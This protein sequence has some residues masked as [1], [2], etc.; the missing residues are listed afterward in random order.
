VSKPSYSERGAILVPALWALVILSVLVAGFAHRMSIEVGMAGLRQAQLRASWLARSGIRIG[1]IALTEDPSPEYDSRKEAWY[2]NPDLYERYELEDGWVSIVAAQPDGGGLPRFGIA[3]EE[4]RINLNTA[5]RDVLERVFEDHE[6]VVPAI[7]DWRDADDNALP[8]GAEASYYGNLDSPYRCRNGDFATFEE[9]QLVRGMTP[10]IMEEVR[11]LVTTYGDG[12]VNVNT[13]G[14]RVLECLGLSEDV[15]DA[16]LYHRAGS[17]GTEGTEDDMVFE[18][19][20]DLRAGLTE[21]IEL[22]EEEIGQID[23][24]V[25]GG[26]LSVRSRFYRVRAIGT[27][28]AGDARREITAVV[29]RQAGDEPRVVYWYE[30]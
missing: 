28:S 26:Y 11:G 12:K 14:R 25:A 6:D 8:G 22:T 5:S 29:E 17:D 2:D 20:E 9:I 1:L 21:H 23:G 18:E 3:D 4:S 19:L 16:F 15:A 24:L 30:A 7:L 13:C 10:E 27:T